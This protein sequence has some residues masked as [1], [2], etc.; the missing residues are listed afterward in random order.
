MSPHPVVPRTSRLKHIRVGRLTCERT[1]EP[2]AYASAHRRVEVA[3]TSLGWLVQSGWLV[4]VGRLVFV[5]LR[6]TRISHPAQHDESAHFEVP[7]Q[8]IQFAA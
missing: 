7:R 2:L 8:P 3:A 4:L 5:E 1:D 6:E